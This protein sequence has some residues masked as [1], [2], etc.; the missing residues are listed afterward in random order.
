[1]LRS[2]PVAIA[3]GV[4]A[5]RLRR[6]A[7]GA[8]MLLWLIVAGLV[9]PEARDWVG[10]V[11]APL[12]LAAWLWAVAARCPRCGYRVG[13]RAFG[14]LFGCGRCDECRLPMR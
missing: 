8:V 11:G 2:D 6:R 9:P 13:T 3:G 12:V 7:M 1:M 10:W 5:I 4:R 14:P